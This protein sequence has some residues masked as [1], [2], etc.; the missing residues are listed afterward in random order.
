MNKREEEIL[1]YVTDE[2]Q[3]EEKIQFEQQLLE[4]P[5]LQEE[6]NKLQ[7]TQEALQEWPDMDFDLPSVST[8]ET[9]N[10]T[11]AEIPK[12]LSVHRWIPYAAAILLL[13]LFAWITDLQVSQKDNAMIFSFGPVEEPVSYNTEQVAQ[14]VDQ[15]VAKY[16]D[17]ANSLKI[18]E[19]HKIDEQFSNLEKS[20]TSKLVALYRNELMDV[21]QQL[22]D[23]ER[24]QLLSTEELVRGLQLEQRVLLQDAILA[25]LDQFEQ[26]RLEDRLDVDKAFER[27]TV[28]LAQI[29]SGETTFEKGMADLKGMHY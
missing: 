16:A 28:L 4:D 17:Q 12:K 1:R 23:H 5:D 29:Q 2:M 21:K 26:Q 14:I 3:P 24:K 19:D 13:P 7:K 27:I 22:N 8:F 15:A 11:K 10:P 25:I 20:M 6:I 18:K 9:G